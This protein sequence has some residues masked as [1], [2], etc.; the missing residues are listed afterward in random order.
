M[1]HQ[2]LNKTWVKG[3]YV[4]DIPYLGERVEYLP[5]GCG[6]EQLAADGPVRQEGA[7]HAQHPH[8]DTQPGFATECIKLCFVLTWH[9][10]W[11]SRDR[12]GFPSSCSLGISHSGIAAA[13]SSFR[14]TPF[15]TSE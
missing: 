12:S 7:D 14:G 9:T 2:A 15:Y 4:M 10:G 5:S 6:G 1:Q 8:A 11:R 13:L 3:H